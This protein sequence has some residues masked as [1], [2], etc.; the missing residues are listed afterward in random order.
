MIEYFVYPGREKVTIDKITEDETEGKELIGTAYGMNVNHCLYMG[1]K[2]C[3]DFRERA[4]WYVLTRDGDED[5]E[6]LKLKQPGSI[7]IDFYAE[8]G[9]K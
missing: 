9:M 8:G 5:L 3:K 7:R 2:H 1:S 6:E 4:K